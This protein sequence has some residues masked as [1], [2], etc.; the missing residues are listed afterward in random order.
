LLDELELKCKDSH[1]PNG[2]F[3]TKQQFYLK[4]SLFVCAFLLI[5]WVSNQLA[6]SFNINMP[7]LSYF[8]VAVVMFVAFVSHVK[9]STNKPKSKK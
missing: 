6:T 3:V 2:G 7:V 4:L 1:I 9:A 5:I 8:M